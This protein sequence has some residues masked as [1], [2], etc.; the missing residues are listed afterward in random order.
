MSAPITIVQAFHVSCSSHHTISKPN[1]KCSTSSLWAGAKSALRFAPLVQWISVVYI[2]DIKLSTSS[3]VLRPPPTSITPCEPRC[4]SRPRCLPRS[5]RA[6][7]PSRSRCARHTVLSPT[8]M[9]PER[10]ASLPCRSHAGRLLRACRYVLHGC[11][12]LSRTLMHLENTC[13]LCH[14]RNGILMCVDVD[15]VYC[16][17]GTRMWPLVHMSQSLFLAMK[18]CSRW[19]A[20]RVG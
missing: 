9:H 3:G 18:L 13:M 14:F 5:A 11:T 6:Y 17:P 16:R 8:S 7:C 2:I 10:D 19:R 20:S 15:G 12:S 1:R 4:P